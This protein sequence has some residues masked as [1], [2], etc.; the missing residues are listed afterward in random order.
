[1]SIVKSIIDRIP[2][3]PK[4]Y[5][6]KQQLRRS[7]LDGGKGNK[8]AT[9]VAVSV[10]LLVVGT[11]LI[12]ASRYVQ[13]GYLM[14]ALPFLAT[15]LLPAMISP[16]I[17]GEYQ[18]RSLEQLLATPLKPS[19]IVF[20]KALRGVIPT[21]MMLAIVLGMIF[22]VSIGKLF[23]GHDVD[24][25]VNS[26]F[27]S[28]PICIVVFILWSFFVTSITIYVSSVTKTTSA[29]LLGSFGIQIGLFFV[30]P[31][32]IAPLVTI[33][34]GPEAIG[35]FVVTH[36]VGL[37]TFTVARDT[38]MQMVPLVL[39]ALFALASYVATGFAFLALA[40]K[41]LGTYRQTGFEN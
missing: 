23:Y 22:F 29:A 33:A 39:L 3:E 14:L 31:A 35:Y 28:V 27:I 30:V 24:N 26:P 19:E 10:I 2:D 17:S 21:L 18:R 15:F 4:Y 36:P 40:A 12:F 5:E 11:N 9:I 34:G 41:K 13:V 38:E 16:L 1:M 20:A 8:I 32:I 25:F 37:M 6:L 7:S